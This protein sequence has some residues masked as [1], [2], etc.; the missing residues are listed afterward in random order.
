[1]MDKIRILLLKFS[2]EIN[3]DIVRICNHANQVDH[4]YTWKDVDFTRP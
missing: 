4:K 2:L 3:K 1:M